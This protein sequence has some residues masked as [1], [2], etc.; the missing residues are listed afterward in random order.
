M[1]KQLDTETVLTPTVNKQIQQ[2][3]RGNA[4]C[5]ISFWNTSEPVS[6]LSRWSAALP[7]SRLVN[8]LFGGSARSVRAAGLSLE[9]EK[10]HLWR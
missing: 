8:E 7:V 6:P 4:G 5:Q 9:V 10:F 1:V 2:T 3:R